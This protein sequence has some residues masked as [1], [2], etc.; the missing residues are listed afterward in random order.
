MKAELLKQIEDQNKKY[1]GQTVIATLY[2][3][4][5]Q[6]KDFLIDLK[7]PK[8][9]DMPTEIHWITETN[10]NWELGGNWY[11]IDHEKTLEYQE[12]SKELRAIKDE[13]ESIATEAG[14]A[15][16]D[17]IKSIGKGKKNLK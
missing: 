17:A 16:A 3:L 8:K 12:K 9:T 13:K 11:E 1:A 15:V 2:R 14:I 5:Q 10:L 4:G 7:M 6:G